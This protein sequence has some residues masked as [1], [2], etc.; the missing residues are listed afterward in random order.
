M[1]SLARADALPPE[2]SATPKP[3]VVTVETK[4]GAFNFASDPGETLLYAGLRSG[5]TLPHECATGT[6]GTCRARVMSGEVEICW[7]AAPGAAKL[8]RDKGDVLMCQARALGDCVLRV[9]SE[10]AQ[11]PV[12]HQ[13]PAH[14]TGTVEN[15]RRLTSDVTRFEVALSEP[16]DFDAGQ[17]VVVEAPGLDGARAYSMVNYGPGAD[18]IELV[19]KRKPGGGF[20]D[21]LFDGGAAEGARI[22]LFGPLGRATFHPEENRNLLMIAG[23]SGIAGMMSILARAAAHDYF[24]DRKGYVFFGVRTLADGFYLEQF[25]RSLRDGHGNLEVTLAISNED[26]G[27]D[28]RHPDHPDVRL[29]TGFVHEVAGQAMAGR[30]EDV[31]AYVAGPPPMVDGALRTLIAQGGLSPSSIR[32]DKFG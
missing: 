5:L 15:V 6:C 28:A 16:M 20:G 2:L 12:R 8:K 13:I 9:P 4:S 1:T 22:K 31:M 14:R 23:G 10:V 24:R 21:W 19:V 26:V 30:Y 18:R 3:G 11:K 7:D 17:F 32:Y 25:A 27:C 29:A